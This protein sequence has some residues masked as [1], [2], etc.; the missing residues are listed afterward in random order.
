M[1]TQDKKFT[2]FE[3]QGMMLRV[4]YSTYCN[5]NGLAVVLIDTAEDETYAVLS[6]NVPEVHL[7]KN[8]F[9]AKT[10]SE[11]EPVAAHVLALGLFKDTGRRVQT[12]YVSSPIWEVKK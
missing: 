3:F 2:A 10:Y 6:I 5:G 4:E 1:N 7:F 9:I 11:N 8:Q 12:G